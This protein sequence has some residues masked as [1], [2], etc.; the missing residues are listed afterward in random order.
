MVC[1]Q[2]LVSVLTRFGLYFVLIC[3]S[4]SGAA[5][6][7]KNGKAFEENLKDFASMAESLSGGLKTVAKAAKL[8]SGD[9][10]FGEE[11]DC[12]FVC[13]NGATPRKKIGYVPEDN[14]CGA[15]GL[16]VDLSKLPQMEQCCTSHDRCYGQCGME[17]ETCDLRFSQCLEKVCNRL[18]KTMGLTDEESE[19]CMMTVQLMYMTVLE[20]GCQAYLDAQRQACICKLTAD[21]NRTGHSGA[22]RKTKVEL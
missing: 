1:P 11:E 10:D 14:G 8:L 9:I 19:G 16:K 7:Q 21:D 4:W 22:K 3:T 15:Y 20:L 17:K 5:A 6:D 18:L 13:K 2:I 12:E